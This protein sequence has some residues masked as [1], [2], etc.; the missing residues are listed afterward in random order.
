MSSSLLCPESPLSFQHLNFQ[1]TTTL[2]GS[3]AF[4]GR[5]GT[6]LGRLGDI[7]GDYHNGE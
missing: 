1:H 2:H 7:D 3:G 6:A 4:D 5:F